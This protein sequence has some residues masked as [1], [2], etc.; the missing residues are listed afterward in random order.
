MNPVVTVLA[1][2][3]LTQLVVEDEITA[4]IRDGIVT[5]SNRYREGSWQDR[6]G[7]LVTCPACTSVWAGAA[8]LAAAHH[9]VGRLL[10]RVLAASGAALL[11]EAVIGRLE[12]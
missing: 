2:Q 9:P 11:V 7:Y 5:W 4:P 3:R 10:A 6:L 1:T 12:R 8:L